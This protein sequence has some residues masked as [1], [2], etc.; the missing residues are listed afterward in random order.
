[1]GYNRVIFSKSPGP[2]VLILT[3]IKTY[4]YKYIYILKRA[5]NMF[6]VKQIRMRYKWF[7]ESNDVP[8]SYCCT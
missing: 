6:S 7:F 3:G 5:S 4:I 2:F 1:M 8:L